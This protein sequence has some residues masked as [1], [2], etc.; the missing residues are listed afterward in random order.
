M[1]NLDF[2]EIYNNTFNIFN[3]PAYARD[4]PILMQDILQIYQ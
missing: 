1:S 3:L 4:H 2:R